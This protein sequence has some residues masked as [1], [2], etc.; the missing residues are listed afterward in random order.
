MSRVEMIT[1]G[2]LPC[3]NSKNKKSTQTMTFCSNSQTLEEIVKSYGKTNIEGKI[4][5][6]GWLS[7]ITQALNKNKG[8]VQTQFI[9]AFFTA[10]VAP[11]F[12][13][14][15]PISKQ[16]KKTK[17]YTA[18]R[19]PISAINAILISVPLTTLINR[20]T[21]MIASKG[22]IKSL[23]LRSCPDESYLKT[24]FAQDYNKVKGNP[25]ELDKFLNSFSTAESRTAKEK[26]IR[27]NFPKAGNWRLKN[28]QKK[29]LADLYV[30]AKQKEA[31]DFY[32]KL[33]YENPDILR[34]N[35][36]IRARVSDLD[37]YLSR[38]NLHELD[39]GKLM[40]DKFGVEFI[41]EKIK[42]G[43]KTKEILHLK[44]NALDKKIKEIKGIDFLRELG[45][46][47]ATIGEDGKYTADSFSEED[48]RRFIDRIDEE[49][50]GKTFEAHITDEKGR[51]HTIK[52]EFSE[53]TLRN[54]G[55]L[56][57]RQTERAVGSELLNRNTISLYDLIKATFGNQDKKQFENLV[58]NNKT[59]EVIE[60]FVQKLKGM[61]KL[62]GVKHKGSVPTLIDVSKQM[63]KL[64]NKIF[65]SK[66]GGTKQYVGIFFNLGIVAITCTTLNW[67]YPRIVEKLFPSLL[68]D[69][70]PK[71]GGNK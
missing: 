25:N 61:D 71:K 43:G 11:L 21:E 17:E 22:F 19:Q 42:E 48:L 36:E 63:M 10:T 56:K 67:A 28:E 5:I 54:Q 52:G 46:V 33:M 65:K 4:G 57:A 20:H 44:E 12:I 9:N 64:K 70:K 47:E 35:P 6:K 66:F 53:E 23:D 55:K 24:L 2:Y 58:K 29:G 41:T 13:A 34:N 32:T 26:E 18:L 37:D 39:F 7:R 14:F 38:N 45:F 27:E 69:D 50:K 51:I 3:S 60:I 16:D 68:A 15:N 31:T 30:K 40:K 62:I 49:K 59:A 8:E 1:S